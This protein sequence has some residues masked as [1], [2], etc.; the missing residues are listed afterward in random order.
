M[1]MISFYFMMSLKLLITIY[2][3]YHNNYSYVLFFELATYDF[4]SNYIFD[5]DLFFA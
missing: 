4:Y 1:Y 5:E 3:N 2:K